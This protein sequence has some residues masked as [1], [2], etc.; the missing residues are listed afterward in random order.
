MK[1]YITLILLVTLIMSCS[2]SDD[3]ND[4]CSFLL[5]VGVNTSINLNLPQFTDLQFP[6]NSVYIPNFGNGGIIV[7]N[8]GGN[9]RAWDAS[10]PNHPP[11]SC[12]V[13]QINGFIGTCGCEDANEYELASGTAT[14]GQEG[15]RC[16]LRSYRVENNGNILNISN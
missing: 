16:S 5:N 10:D 3:N 7:I 2:N 12:S 9:F 6:S 8:V 1:K 4:N 15:L 14:E 11:V 13:L